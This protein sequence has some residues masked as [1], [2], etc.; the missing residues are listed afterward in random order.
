MALLDLIKH[1]AIG[2]VLSIL[3]IVGTGVVCAVVLVALRF[4]RRGSS[5]FWLAAGY[6]A[7][8]LLPVALGAALSGWR[9][10]VLDRLL[11]LIESGPSVAMRA[12]FN[13]TL[14]PLLCGLVAGSGLLLLAFVLLAVGRRS[15]MAGETGAPGAL[16]PVAVLVLV[17]AIMALASCIPLAGWA[18]AE[19]SA[20]SGSLAHAALIGGIVCAVAAAVA[21]ILLA[22]RSPHGAAP[23]AVRAL[24]LGAPVV[25]GL[26][27]TVAAIAGTV[28][29]IGSQRAAMMGVPLGGPE[30][31]PPVAQ[32]RPDLP[33]VAPLPPPPPPP[34]APRPMSAPDTIEQAPTA[35]PRAQ[36]ARSP[37]PS[38]ARP[39]ASAQAEQAPP[40]PIRIGGRIKEPRKLRS[41]NPVYPAIAQRARVQGVVVLECRISPQGKVTSVKVLRG[42]P[43]LNQAAIDAVRQWEYEPT[44]LYGA[45]V[46]VIMTVTVNFRLN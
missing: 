11:R 14:V 13:E 29:L 6:V 3:A 20:R 42:S 1:L 37:V 28:W 7:L 38:A 27:V 26:A 5:R 31:P 33:M 12:G 8:A 35:G 16:A 10:G 4:L 32:P 25:I 43:L 41:V 17:V 19:A 44:L 24:A 9:L 21:G 39:G 46:P 40:S 34:P 15:E 45:P 36:D 2:T 30:L 22:M 18:L 23:A